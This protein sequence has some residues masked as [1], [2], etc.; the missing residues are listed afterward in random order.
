MLR[1]LG[2][3]ATIGMQLSQTLIAGVSQAAR[4]VRQ[5]ASTVLEQLK[6]MFAAVAEVGGQDFLSLFVH[7]HLCFLGVPLL[8]A[9]VVSTLSFLGRSMGCSLASIKTTS[10]CV[11]LACKTFLPGR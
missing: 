4:A 6:I 1:L 2:R 11:S 10:I 7:D 8:F 9:A 3:G 5:E